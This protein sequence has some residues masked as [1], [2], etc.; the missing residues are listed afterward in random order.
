MRYDEGQA[1]RTVD[2][3]D[4]DGFVSRIPNGVEVES[5]SDIMLYTDIQLPSLPSVFTIS[6][7]ISPSR[8]AGP[9]PACH[10]KKMGGL[11]GQSRNSVP[12][13]QS[14]TCQRRN[15]YDSEPPSR[16]GRDQLRR[17]APEVLI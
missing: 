8:G 7:F 11:R 15:K 4:W 5:E 14:V 1:R 13:L 16:R 6:R 17:K 12:F 3:A 2:H 9:S 10:P